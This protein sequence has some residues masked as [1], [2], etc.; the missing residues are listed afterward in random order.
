MTRIDTTGFVSSTEGSRSAAAADVDRTD[1]V[2]DLVRLAEL[3]EAGNLTDEE[4]AAAKLE[5]LTEP[6]ARS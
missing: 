4:F 5:R 2:G 3:H 6:D 1:L